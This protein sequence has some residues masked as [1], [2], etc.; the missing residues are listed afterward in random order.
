MSQQKRFEHHLVQFRGKFDLVRSTETINHKS[1]SFGDFAHN[2]YLN[3][4]RT[5]LF[6]L[7]A[8]ARIEQKIGKQSKIPNRWLIKQSRE[9]P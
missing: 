8:L 3:D 7:Q 9:S 6:Q 5:P 4:A 1:F 2:L